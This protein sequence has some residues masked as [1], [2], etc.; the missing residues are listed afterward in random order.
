MKVLVTGGAGFIG[1]WL[2]KRLLDEKNEV[3]AID[4]FSNGRHEN[5]QEFENHKNFNFV[6][7][8]IRNPNTLGKL[9]EI[10]Y[11]TV[12]HLA[13]EIN[14][15]N[16]IDDPAQTVERDILG[17]FNVLE[18][19]KKNKTRLV[20]MSTCMVYDRCNNKK[21]I[22]EDH[23]TKPASPYS[24][25]KISGE[26]LTLSY[27]HAYGLPTS[28]IRP[29]NTYGPFQKTN[30]EGGVVAIFIKQALKNE[31]LRIYG[32]GEQTRDLLYV[33]DCVDFILN[34]ATSNKALGR[35][36][37]AGSGYDVSINNLAE[38]IAGNSNFLKHVDHIHPQAEIMKLKC[39]YD[40]AK[41]LL[42]WQPQ[43]SLEEGLKKTRR[44]IEE[45]PLL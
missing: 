25:A 33:E 9:F 23:P 7:G 6:K 15:Q 1:R 34:A 41:E 11:D 37:N 44:W 10:K 18:H 12:Y 32:T 8:D 45:N 20:F 43:H 40:L 22:S 14:V 17:T 26:A 13:A 21:G 28:V 16:S 29:F 38:M 2:V 30:G 24:A 19:C 4:D 35:I 31:Q 39:N 5:I 3:Y 42:K 27:Y 36:I